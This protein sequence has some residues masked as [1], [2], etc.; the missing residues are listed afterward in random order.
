MQNSGISHHPAHL[1][2]LHLLVDLSKIFYKSC[3]SSMN[4]CQVKLYDQLQHFQNQDCAPASS[5]P[6]RSRE[7]LKLIR[8]LGTDS[9]NLPKSSSKEGTKDLMEKS[10][11]QK[12]NFLSCTFAWSFITA[13]IFKNIVHYTA[14][15]T[16]H[17]ELW[18]YWGLFVWQL[19][20]N[21][22]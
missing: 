2:L 12:S 13:C 6:Q 15:L 18:I 19:S 20:K 5:T 22:L 1:P 4:R 16:C 8:K 11:S 3:L 9:L 21:E 14:T 10:K 7:V 17:S